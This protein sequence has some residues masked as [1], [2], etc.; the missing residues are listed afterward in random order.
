MDKPIDERF[1]YSLRPAKNIERKL[2]AE[3]FRCADRIAPLSQYRYVGFGSRFFN[4]FSL[5]HRMF[6]IENMISIEKD[7]SRKQRFLINKPLRTIHMKWGVATDVLPKLAWRRRAI[8]WLDYE[9]RLTDEVLKDI[10]TVIFPARS[11]SVIAVTVN[12]HPA[13]P[14]RRPD[15]THDFSPR[16]ER[17]K[18]DL[19]DDSYKIPSDVSSAN[20][21]SRWALASIQARIIHNEITAAINSRN[22]G[23]PESKQVSFRTLINFRYADGAHMLTFGGVVLNAVDAAKAAFDGCDIARNES[24]PYMIEVPVLTDR[25][26]QVLDRMLPE[27]RRPSRTPAWL[28]ED[29]WARYRRVYR[30]FPAFVEA[31]R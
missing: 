3:V 21:V 26:R 22:S 16:L 31:E 17:L 23:K 6:G 20:V 10:S 29:D 27:G 18:Q 2:L 4:D 5:Y 13:S 30:F 11:G 8:V 9:S 28:G 7:I 15:G 24:E 19:G 25:E 12:A 1:D 14:V